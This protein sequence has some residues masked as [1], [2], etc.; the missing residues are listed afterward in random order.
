MFA[1]QDSF[2]CCSSPHYVVFD[3][4]EMKTAND[5]SGARLRRIS[6]PEEQCMLSISN[7]VSMGC[8]NKLLKIETAESRKSLDSIDRQSTNTYIIS[9]IAVLGV[10]LLGY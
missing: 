5:I 2:L 4:I 9:P 10:V 3:R 1:K 6:G 8:C 7:R